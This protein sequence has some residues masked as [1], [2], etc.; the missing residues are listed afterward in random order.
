MK[1]LLIF[2]LLFSTVFIADAQSLI[3][4]NVTVLR[5][6]D[7]TA[8]LGSS[9][10]AISLLEYNNT[11]ANQ[12]SP[13]KTTAISSTGTDRITTGGAVT[14]EG[15]LSL[16]QDGKFLCFV[17]Y[18]QPTGSATAQ[19]DKNAVVGLVDYAGVVDY[20]T[21]YT[22][23]NSGSARGAAT[24]DGNSIW[25]NVTNQSVGYTTRG[26]TTTAV[27]TGFI[28][29]PR[30]INIQDDK[31][32]GV[33][34]GGAMVVA[35]PLPTSS[36]TGSTVFN[37][38]IGALSFVFLDVSPTANWA[39][40]GYDVLYIV[41]LGTGLEKYY[42]NGSAWT[43]LNTVALSTAISPNGL[44]VSA[45][46]ATLNSLGQPVI[47]LT[48]GYGQTTNNRLMKLIDDS[49]YNVAAPTNPT[50]TLTTLATAGTNYAF[51][52][53]AFAPAQFTLPITL[54]SFSG[55]LINTKASLQWATTSEINAKEFVIERSNTA[56]DF[57]AV[58]T[59]TARNSGGGSNYTFDDANLSKGI[60]YYRLKL[61]DKDGSFK[62]SNVVAIKLDD[63]ATHGLSIFPNPV[64]STLTFTHDK[65]EDGTTIK[66]VAVSGKTIAQYTVAKNATQTSIDASQF[67]SGQYFINY[68]GNGKNVT[69]SFIKH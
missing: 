1:Y 33:A 32:Y 20:S 59:V 58:G 60:N 3:N 55:S 22:F 8:T 63:K 51:R 46:T 44:G 7:G 68:I 34:N 18:N 53:I 25:V 66:I 11:T 37:P 14:A 2:S 48:T 27:G 4:R 67:M 61:V 31:I 10:A 69:T 29:G 17:G 45:I 65:A 5:V 28:T 26:A 36:T 9:T 49:G 64:T 19:A 13:V 12:T 23:N 15:Q 62:Y 50:T 42:W 56:N 16:S 38:N 39:G 24:V 35:D 21:K 30:A 54:S 57:L 6:G 52:G 40:T 41:N 43:G 47:Y